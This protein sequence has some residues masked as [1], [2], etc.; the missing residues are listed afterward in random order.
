MYFWKCVISWLDIL[1]YGEYFS[2]WGVFKVNMEIKRE[3]LILNY[4]IC[5]PLILKW[6]CFKVQFFLIAIVFQIS[7]FLFFFS[8]V[9]I[10]LL[11]FV[12]FLLIVLNGIMAKSF[13]YIKTC[14]I[15]FICWLMSN[16]YL[17]NF[18]FYKSSKIIISNLDS[19][20]K[21]WNCKLNLVTTKLI[22]KV[23]IKIIKK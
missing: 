16:T 14:N 15:N 22:A 12:I 23:R 3:N 19:S 8:I 18:G 6:E 13:H 7:N 4:H 2:L 9:Y 1:G 17:I 10:Y 11:A 21:F 5:D 20:N